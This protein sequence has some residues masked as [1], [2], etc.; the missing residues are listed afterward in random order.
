MGSPATLVELLDLKATNPG[1]KVV[2]GNTEVGVETK[3]KGSRFPVLIAATHVPE[4][5]ILRETPH[6]VEVGGAVTLTALGAFLRDLVRT[7]PASQV[8]GRGV[9]VASVMASTVVV[10]VTPPPPPVRTSA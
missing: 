8:C 10:V 2:V 7:T 5:N 6:G 4:L 3:F 1:A 9:Y